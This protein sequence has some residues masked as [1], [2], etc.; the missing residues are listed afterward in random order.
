MKH[1]S[2]RILSLLVLLST[3]CNSE[4]KNASKNQYPKYLTGYWIPKEIKWEIEDQRYKD[5]GM[6]FQTSFF[7]TLCFDTTNKFIYLGATQRHQ[8]S[9]NDSLVFAGEPIVTVF[10][11]SWHL[12]NDTLLKVDF[13]PMESDINPHDEK[14]A[15]IKILFENDTLLLFENKL[16]TRT[17]KYDKI[18]QQTIEEYKK[19]YWK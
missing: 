13:K 17:Q 5:S 16:Y 3:A 1:I 19:H 12:I 9:N 2:I 7:R 14:Q 8:K 15:Q 6:M 18:S 10:G 11:G 4:E